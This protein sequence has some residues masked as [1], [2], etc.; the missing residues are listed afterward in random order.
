MTAR[1][2]GTVSE[3]S[4]AIDGFSTAYHNDFALL[5][6][7]GRMYIHSQST[8]NV[9]A[10]S[11]ALREVLANWGAGRRK[12]PALRS[13][14]SF[15]ISLNAPAL[16]RDLALLHALPLSSLT[17]VGNQPSLANSSTPAVTVAAFDAC[18]FRTLAALSTGLF[19]GN[20]NVTYPMKAALLIAG[21][22]P[23]FD[24]QVRR[25]LQRGGFIGMNKTQHLLPRNALYAGGMKVA[26]LPFLLGQCWSAY[27]AQFAAG[28]SGSNH[29]ALSV[30]PGR[31]FDVLFFMQGNPQ[32]PILI[33]HHGANKWYEMP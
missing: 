8:A 13:V 10:L 11:E 29:R 3:V 27:A 25:G 19:N 30:E 17:L 31:V 4:A 32:Q 21:V 2:I 18:L 12:A 15:K 7:F 33:Q 16:H 1:L 23:A 6:D 22:M 20:T 24:S 9:S 14:D 28:L 5:R 26:R